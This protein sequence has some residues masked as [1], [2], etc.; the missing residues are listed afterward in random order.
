MQLFAWMIINLLVMYTIVS[1]L[2]L[3]KTHD[4]HN[5]QL[6][7]QSRSLPFFGK[8]NKPVGGAVGKKKGVSKKKIALGGALLGAGA[9]TLYKAAKHAGKFDSKYKKHNQGQVN[10]IEYFPSTEFY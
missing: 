2:H 9:Y 10:S 8:K 4:G 5:Y 1:P 3:Q 6:S 7:R